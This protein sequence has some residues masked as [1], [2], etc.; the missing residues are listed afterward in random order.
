M[1]PAARSLRT[2][3]ALVAVAGVVAVLL[4]A[5]VGWDARRKAL[6]AA[7]DYTRNTAAMLHEHALKVFHTHAL[8]LNQVD[9][10]TEGR[11]W[12]DI[13]GD[14]RL[15]RSLRAAAEGSEQVKS[16]WV[17]DA[18]GAL[19]VGSM[20]VKQPVNVADRDYFL[21]HH[22]R[23]GGIYI[24]APYTGRVL[25]SA[26]F[27]VSRRRMAPPGTFDGIV[28]V[29]IDPHYFIDFWKDV[30]PSDLHAAVFLTRADGTIL[31]RYPALPDAQVRLPG[32]SPLVQAAGHA[33]EGTG[34]DWRSSIDGTERIVSFKKL[35]GYPV[36]VSFSVGR[37][38]VIAR[39]HEDR[40]WHRVFAL[41]ALAALAALG[42]LAVRR[43]RAQADAEA[44]LRRQLGVTRAITEN[45]AEALFLMDA[46]GRV[47]FMN[48]AAER[49]FGWTA[50]EIRGDL[51][52]DRLHHHHPNGRLFPLGDCPLVGAMAAG[53]T[54]RDHEDLLFCKNGTPVHVI[55]SNAPI[56][57]DGR[58]TGAVLAIRDIT[59]R[60]ETEEALRK[61]EA[62]LS[63][64]Q[65]VASIG[66]VE[67]DVRSDT[68]RWSAE[69]Y[70][71]LGRA[72]DSFVLTVENARAIV[73][74]D[75]VGAMH[76][77]RDMVADGRLPSAGD[78]LS[79]YRIIRPDG[80]VRVVRRECDLVF[81]AEGEVVSVIGTLQDV[82]EIREAERERG[83]FEAQ[84]LHS[85][86]LESLGTLAGGIAHDLNNTLTPI[87]AL[88]KLVQA[89]LPPQSREHR[90]LE[91]VRQAGMRARDLVKQI[92]AF[93]RREAPKM[94]VVQ[95]PA[96]VDETLAMLR[97]TT[98]ATIRIDN[99]TEDVPP[100]IADP[101]QLQQVLV[102]LV[103][104][105]A[106]AIGGGMG[107]I[108]VALSAKAGG[109]AV[110]L[111]VTDTG[112]G[113]D[114][115]TRRRMFDP[116]FTTKSAGEGT[117]LGL[118]VVH[119]IVSSHVGRID[120]T[121]TPGRGTRIDV[122]LPMLEPEST[123]GRSGPDA[124]AAA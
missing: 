109:G 90:N 75:D 50:D 85:Q 26:A 35:A 71:I 21:A 15:Q 48:P 70:R 16:I 56:V 59:R 29:S 73:H 49:M 46:E 119:G 61:S 66:S 94:E 58:V 101:G 93:S 108:S 68:L 6:E 8:I 13:L 114:D 76:G 5:F 84:L 52:H 87:V 55:C 57:A 23:D 3:T 40:A 105:A 51:L 121:S 95:L 45:T 110:C 99:S 123:G 63:R 44:D 92:L 12:D 38:A 80:E 28:L 43:A 88:S 42:W 97:A 64:A 106:Q 104:N 24:S 113:M 79:E 124:E 30:A 53:T 78:L 33:A 112:C 65:Q 117:G 91:L 72:R 47:T 36:Y 82:T 103:T 102:N 41:T 10:W 77:L 19:R 37:D 67:Y 1:V 22:D 32:S 17:S 31:A 96:L 69:T 83:E 34:T 111:S 11:D 9:G 122:H 89:N 60:K 81:D 118:A 27:A 2:T 120:V 54:L 18:S 100:V 107:I 74:P 39:W 4:F 25:G 20:P 7:A 86:K 62:H 14:K 116:F 115:A 98:P